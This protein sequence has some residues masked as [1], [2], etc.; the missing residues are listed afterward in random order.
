MEMSMKRDSENF[1]LSLLHSILPTFMHGADMENI[2][3]FQNHI[4]Y[5]KSY[6]EWGSLLKENFIENSHRLTLVME[7]SVSYQNDR[8]LE[9]ENILSEKV[10]LLTDTDKTKLF[11]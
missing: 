3:D 9:E 4:D 2:C 6:D 10:G 8:R 7:P 1:G 11:E 5:I